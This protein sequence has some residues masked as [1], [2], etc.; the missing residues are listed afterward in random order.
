MLVKVLD[1]NRVKILME[2]R[3]IEL[4]NLPFEKLNYD[5]PFSR[6]FLYELIQKTFEQTGVNFK[7]CHVMIEVIPGV[8]RSYY[9]LLSK[10]LNEGVGQIEFDKSER[11]ESDEYIFKV[12]NGYEVLRFSEK[13]RAFSVLHCDLYVYKE[14]FYFVFAFSTR[15]EDLI[16]S[17]LSELEEYGVKCRYHITNEAILHEWGVHLFG[18]QIPAS[19]ISER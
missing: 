13:L 17:A 9:I 8:S 4:Y 2:D 14:L 15:N 6:S 10:M 1:E 7:D 12:Q 18:P 5:D 16:K 19:V 3:D 11:I